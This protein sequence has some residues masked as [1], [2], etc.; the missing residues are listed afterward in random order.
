MIVITII[1]VIVIIIIVRGAFLRTL[2][3][4]YF[5]FRVAPEFQGVYHVLYTLSLSL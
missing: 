3:Q 1:I 4:L 5:S 2:I